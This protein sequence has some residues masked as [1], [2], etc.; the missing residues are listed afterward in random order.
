MIDIHTHL[1]PGI[2]DGVATLDEAR[3]VLDQYQEAGFT[4]LVCTPHI[5]HPAVDTRV[6]R[7]RTRYQEVKQEAARRG[8]TL[9]LGSEVY[10]TSNRPSAGIPIA[11]RFQLIEFNTQI[12]PLFLTEVMF[13]FS[14]LG[15]DVIIA[16]VDRYS[17]FDTQDPLIKR[18]KEMGASFQLN[19]DALE[20]SRGRDLAASGMIDFLATDHHGLRRGRVHL[21]R[22]AEYPEITARGMKLLGLSSG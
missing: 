1:L 15:F 4:H 18:V 3:S 20:T 16:H 17:W 10:V 7:I 6:D 12:K 8:M 22:F 11:K 9:M 21:E 13:H 19:I 14:L 5:D 2:D